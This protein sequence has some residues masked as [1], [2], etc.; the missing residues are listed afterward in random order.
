M[1]MNI[2]H[3]PFK[4]SETNGFYVEIRVSLSPTDLT[5]SPTNVVAGERPIMAVWINTKINSIDLIGNEVNN[6]SKSDKYLMFGIEDKPFFLNQKWL[7]VNL[8][9]PAAILPRV[10]GEVKAYIH[11]VKCFNGGGF[12]DMFPSNNYE[13]FYGGND[14]G[15]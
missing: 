6:E 15:S 1:N 10:N 8:R 3:M 12:E 5:D 7:W 14:A 9:G 11:E 4:Y 2:I 13:V